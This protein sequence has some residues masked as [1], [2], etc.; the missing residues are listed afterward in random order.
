[1]GLLNVQFSDSSETAIIAYFSGPQDENAV[2]N[3]G[4]LAPIDP[5]WDA[6]YT[7][8]PALARQALPIP[9]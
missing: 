5:R 7:T 3:Q 8:R 1:M 6:F 9:G 2:P 4:T